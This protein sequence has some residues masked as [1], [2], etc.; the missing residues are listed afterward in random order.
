M[1]LNDKDSTN[2]HQ[3]LE[4]TK[5]LT[6]EISVLLL[7]IVGSEATLLQTCREPITRAI[8]VSITNY[9]NETGHQLTQIEMEK[10]SDSKRWAMDMQQAERIC[11]LQ[12][13]KYIVATIT[14]PFLA[15]DDGYVWFPQIGHYKLHITPV[16]WNQALLACQKEGAHLAIINSELEAEALAKLFAQ[17]PTIPGASYNYIAYLGFNDFAKTGSF[18]TIFGQPLSE[19]GYMK[20]GRGQPS[21]GQHCGALSRDVAMLFDE[22]KVVLNDVWC[23]EKLAFFCEK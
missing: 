3:S 8:K 5:M 17:H 10:E 19:T 14:A 12:R 20:W 7:L 23:E 16:K 4:M 22:S 18:A 6:R 2:F 15:T 1:D 11:G 13:S 21:G 9:V